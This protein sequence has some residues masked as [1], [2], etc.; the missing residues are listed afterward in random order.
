M[1]KYNRA[2][3]VINEVAGENLLREKVKEKMGVFLHQTFFSAT[4]KSVKCII[5]PRG[6]SSD[7]KTESDLP[8]SFFLLSFPF[9]LVYKLKKNY[10]SSFDCCGP[11][12]C[13]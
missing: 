1:Q 4:S 3:R 8:S 12:W 11:K 7:Q 9:A 6:V 13:R 10:A 2:S 5:L